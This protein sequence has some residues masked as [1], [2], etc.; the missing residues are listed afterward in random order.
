MIAPTSWKHLFHLASVP[1]QCPG[2]P[3]PYCGPLPGP[4]LVLSHL[5]NLVT[6]EDFRAWTWT[7]PL[8]HPHSHDKF[9]PSHSLRY[10]CMLMTLQV[11]LAETSFLSS[12]PLCPTAHWTSVFETDSAFQSYQVQTELLTFYSKPTQ[13]SILVLALASSLTL[14]FLSYGL[15][16]HPVCQQILLALHSEYVHVQPFLTICAAIILI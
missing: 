14:V 6:I 8:F 15:H 12:R 13:A 5:P 16:P 2:F 11:S 4:L 9:V 1:P 3:P 10:H 7:T